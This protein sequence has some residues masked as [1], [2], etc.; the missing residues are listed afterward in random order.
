MADDNVD[1]QHGKPCECP[2]QHKAIE[3]RF[4]WRINDFLCL[5]FSHVNP[6]REFAL[7]VHH[8]TLV[9]GQRL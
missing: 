2:G 8:A 4:C 9:P 3:I 6:A 7:R 5:I 1:I